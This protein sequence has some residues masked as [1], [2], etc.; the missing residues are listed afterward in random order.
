L[1]DPDDR[2]G[3]GCLKEATIAKKTFRPRFGVV[4]L[5]PLLIMAWAVAGE[6]FI[7][8]VVGVHDGDTISVMKNG[9]AVKVRLEG[10][11][12]PELGQD[13]GTRAK[14]FTSTLVFDKDVEVKE[15]YPDKYGRMVASIL[16]GGQDVS[17]QLVTAGLAWR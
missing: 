8:R 4:I 3:P 10:I 7:G 1:A 17:L 6:N 15:Y 11:D 5:L 16:V 12:C 14:Q 2:G 9:L 13:F